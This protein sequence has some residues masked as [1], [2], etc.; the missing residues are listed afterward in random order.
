MHCWHNEN[1]TN[2][3]V[4]NFVI[5]A[6][7]FKTFYSRNVLLLKCRPHEVCKTLTSV[8]TFEFSTFAVLEVTEE[9]GLDLYNFQGTISD[10]SRLLK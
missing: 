3:T 9:I 1:F 8:E 5:T 4:C 6:Y 10:V 7:F 2:F